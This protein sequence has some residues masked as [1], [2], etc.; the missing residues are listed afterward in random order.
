MNVDKIRA[1]FPVLKNNFAYL[2]SACMTL[3]PRQV[4][5]AMNRY[6]IEFPACG[7]RSSHRLGAIVTEEYQKA[8]KTTA[9]FIGAGEDELIFTKNTT[10]GLNLA[11]RSL[12]LNK[13]DKVVVSEKEH[14]S[15]FLPWLNFHCTVVKTHNGFFDMEA[16]STAMDRSVKVVAVQHT[17]NI[18]GMSFPIREIGKIAHDNGALLVIDGAQSVPHKEVNVR[19]L[20]CDILAFS[21]HK[22][23]GPSIGAVYVRK[24]LSDQ[25]APFITGGG[26]VLNVLDG[27]PVF[28]QGPEK[29]EGGL[30]NYAGAIGLRAAIDYINGV[31][32]KNIERHEAELNRRMTEGVE[33]L[34]G[35]KILGGSPESRGGILS[36]NI[37]GVDS[38]EAAIMFDSHGV[39]VRGGFHCCHN[40]FN[41]RKL[42]GSIRASLYLYNN[43]KDVDAF[44]DA[45]KKVA[46]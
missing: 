5:E 32:L 24:E 9:K 4:V 10:E 30:Q 6:Y 19:K 34:D 12:N 1:D 18:D 38:R 22:M 27:K 7:E 29:F 45:T 31:G 39:L 14:N 2:D 3:K 8:R 44:I 28:M 42:V 17:S 15:N 21:G 36:I 26:T 20:G 43:E 25:M 23:L 41:A 33:R 37:E 13:S 40:F 35:V 46:A 16:F 11:A